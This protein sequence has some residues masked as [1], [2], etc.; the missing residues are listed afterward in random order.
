MLLAVFPEAFVEAA[1][2]P[3][4][5]SI[6]VLLIVDVLTLVLLLITPHILTISMHVGLFP[7][8]DVMTAIFPLYRAVAIYLSLVP[9][10]VIA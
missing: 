8:A 7:L 2:R 4:V 5:D 10:A 3:L 6:A 9:L 1:I